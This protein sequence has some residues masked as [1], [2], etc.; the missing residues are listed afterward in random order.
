MNTVPNVEVEREFLAV[1]LKTCRTVRAGRR[2][3]MAVPA[4]EWEMKIN[5]RLH[6]M[7]AHHEEEKVAA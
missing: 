6:E 4:A 1:L 2:P 5:E 3:E 7:E